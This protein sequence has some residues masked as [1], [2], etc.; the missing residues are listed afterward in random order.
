MTGLRPTA[1]R[2]TRKYSAQKNTFGLL[3]GPL[4]NGGTC[5]GCTFGRNGCQSIPEGNKLPRCYVE[6][7]IHR[8][9]A[10]ERVLEENTKLIYNANYDKKVMLLAR[11]FRRFAAAEE[12]RDG[13]LNYRLHWS[14]DI[15]DEEY[16]EALREAIE[17]FPKIYFWGYTRSLFSLPI[18][19]QV[20]N[21]CWYV[22][23]DDVNWT[24]GLKAAKE[25]PT[26]HLSYMGHKKPRGFATCPVDAGK[27]SLEGACHKCK[28]CLKGKDVWFKTR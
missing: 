3:P 10:T 21:L 6:H 4:V 28:L 24:E 12:K 8:R 25:Y 20:D 15:P 1:D 17:M 16:A 2:K 18:L 19:S 23:L 5:P 27:M 22:S 11:E 13:D 14:G 9:P 7:I 26:V